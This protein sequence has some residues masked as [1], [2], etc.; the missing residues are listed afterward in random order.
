MKS[1]DLMG[2]NPMW[3]I[4][5]LTVWLPPQFI[6]MIIRSK[7][8]PLQI[9]IKHCIAPILGDL[10]AWFNNSELDRSQK[11]QQSLNFQ[12]IRGLPANR[13][14]RNPTAIEKW[15]TCRSDERGKGDDWASKHVFNGWKGMVWK[16]EKGKEES[17]NGAVMGNECNYTL[18]NLDFWV[19]K[20]EPDGKW[21]N[22]GA[23][24]SNMV[25]N[26]YIGV[27]G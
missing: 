20:L 17:T 22:C 4:A 9:E 8:S 1:L 19:K 27:G 10:D 3:R 16:T 6:Q 15:K 23:S 26:V 7:Q 21:E 11:F 18:K 12:E 2:M 24:S 5:M 25:S 14:G 13:Q